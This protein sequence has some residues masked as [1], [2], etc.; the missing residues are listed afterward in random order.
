MIRIYYEHFDSGQDWTG[1][2]FRLSPSQ[3]EPLT[4]TPTANIAEARS[5]IASFLKIEPNEIRLV[6]LRTQIEKQ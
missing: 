3:A 5:S 4:W 2:T 6:R 1:I